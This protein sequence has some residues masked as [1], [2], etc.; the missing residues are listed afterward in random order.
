MMQHVEHYDAGE[1]PVT[2]RQPVGIA[3]NVDA[4]ECQDIN[5][6]RIL[7]SAADVEHDIVAAGIGDRWL[8]PP[9]P[10]RGVGHIVTQRDD[11]SVRDR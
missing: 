11:F 5:R 8:L 3:S 2:K 10:R 1:L 9:R 6:D 4:G 7:A